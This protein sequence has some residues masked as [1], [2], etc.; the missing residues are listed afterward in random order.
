[1]HAGTVT[2]VFVVA[3][4]GAYLLRLALARRQIRHVAQHRGQVPAAF[5]HTVTLEAHRRAADYT[6]AHARLGLVSSALAAVVLLGWVVI[7][8]GVPAGACSAVQN[9]T[10]SCG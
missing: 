8:G 2:S 10:V 4:V 5:A 7:V 3:L 9:D 1:M 6:L